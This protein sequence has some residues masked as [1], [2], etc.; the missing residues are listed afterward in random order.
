M[1]ARIQKI[2]ALIDFHIYQGLPII[3]G[4]GDFG[5]CQRIRPVV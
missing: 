5:Y 3:A 4:V 2:K 1:F